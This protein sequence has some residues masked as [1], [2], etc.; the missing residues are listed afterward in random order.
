MSVYAVSRM[1]FD[2]AGHNT[3]N[4]R[5][6]KLFFQKSPGK[7]KKDKRGIHELEFRVVSDGLAVRRVKSVKTGMIEVP[8]SNGKAILELWDGSRTVSIYEITE[9]ESPMSPADTILGQQQR[10]R[11]LGYQLGHAGPTGDGVGAPGPPLD[12]SPETVPLPDPEEDDDDR[13]EKEIKKKEREENPAI[14][15]DHFIDLNFFTERS[16]LDFQADAGLFIDGRVG[17][18]T[19]NVIIRAAGE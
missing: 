15:E 4:V 12:I 6:V 8:L 16:I 19:Q 5:T 18:K 13:E 10:L 3:I 9:D 1:V 17:P 14:K 11:H 7:P 2:A